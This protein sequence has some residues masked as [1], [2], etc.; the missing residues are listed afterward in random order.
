MTVTFKRLV[1]GFPLAEMLFVAIS[2][3]KMGVLL[4]QK[5]ILTA[6]LTDF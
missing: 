3:L 5:Q 1:E 2:D 6:N 4:P